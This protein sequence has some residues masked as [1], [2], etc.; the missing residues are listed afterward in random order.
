MPALKHLGEQL[1]LNQLDW[2]KMYI[3]DAKPLSKEKENLQARVQKWLDA[4][5][6][7]ES[8]RTSGDCGR[9]TDHSG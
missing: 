6:S 7:T 5:Q 4:W 8:T 1:A 3:D 9:E 2:T